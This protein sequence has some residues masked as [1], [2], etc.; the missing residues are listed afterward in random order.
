MLEEMSVIYQNRLLKWR[1]QMSRHR[2]KMH[3]KGSWGVPFAVSYL[4]LSLLWTDTNEY[5][6]PKMP[7]NVDCVERGLELCIFLKNTWY[8]IRKFVILNVLHAVKRINTKETWNPTSA[9][10]VWTQKEKE[11]HFC[12]SSIIIAIPDIAVIWLALRITAFTLTFLSIKLN[13]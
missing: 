3:R 9:V 2:W 11:N 10:S 1:I 8:L 13:E 6:I 5:S 7:H 12:A 4:A